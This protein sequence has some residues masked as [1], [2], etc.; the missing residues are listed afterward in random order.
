M[1]KVL[2]V[3]NRVFHYR[4]RIY[5]AFYEKWKAMGWEFHVVSN[6]YQEVDCGYD[7]IKHELPFGSHRYA[8][9]IKELKPDVVINF[10]HLKDR[11]IIPLTICCHRLGIPMIYW[12]HGVN[13]QDPDNKWKNAIFH[14]IHTISDAIILYTPDQLKFISRKNLPKTFIAYNTL[15]FETSDAFRKKMRSKEQIKAQYGIKEQRV[16]LYISR[17]VP[18]KGLDILLSNFQDTKDIALVIVGGGLSEQQRAIIDSHANYYYLG[19]KYGD[20]VD[21]IYSIGDLFST[22]GHIGLALNQA[23]YWGLPVLVLNRK[24]APEIYYMQDG[25]NGFVLEDEQ[26]LKAKVLEL[27]HDD[28]LLQRLSAAARHTYETR[29]ALDNMFDGFEQAVNYVQKQG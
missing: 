4:T 3:S 21:E 10:L 12:N 7:F 24:H 13:L 27:C 26:A 15:N 6:E 29:M 11:M 16:L 1:K 17:I 18:H 8:R 19:E 22:P 28:A 20:E 14:F 25:V 5:N 2:L 23:M 9:F